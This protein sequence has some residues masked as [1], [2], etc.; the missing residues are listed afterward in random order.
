MRLYLSTVLFAVFSAMVHAGES[1]PAPVNSPEPNVTRAPAPKAKSPRT[2]DRCYT[3]MVNCI[4]SDPQ[5]AGSSC[6]C[7]TPFG[8][9]YG[10]VR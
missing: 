2:S 7:V 4:L 5:K 10:T 3:P 8:P 6:W 1:P 9:S